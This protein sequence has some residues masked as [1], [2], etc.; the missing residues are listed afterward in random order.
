V[1]EAAEEYV[2]AGRLTVEGWFDETDAWMFRAVDQ[3]QQ[4]EHGDLVE[5][6]VYLGRSAI[7]LGYLARAGERV[8]AVDL[9]ED[10]APTAEQ[11]VEADRWYRGLQR[12][13]FEDSYR[14]FHEQPT[15]VLQGPS[16]EML[17]QVGEGT[18]RIVHIDGSHSF[19]AVTADIDQACRIATPNAVVIFDD[20]AHRHTVG[21]AAAVWGAVLDGRLVPLAVTGW[22]LY[23][24]MPGSSVTV[25]RLRT[26]LEAH[27]LQ[28][29]REH[30][31]A[32]SSVLE[33]AVE[34]LGAPAAGRSRWRRAMVE[35]VPPVAH[36]VR[37]RGV[38]ELVP[39]IAHRIKHRV[40]GIRERRARARTPTVGQRR[41]T[42][43]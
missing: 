6:G 29:L 26:A 8:V 21:V 31:V 13:R 19:E 43:V 25:E 37:Q 30:Q 10:P 23:T 4:D 9:F 35:L 34:G 5:V 27:P 16:H 24:T 3:L 38:I 39:P 41:P 18:A 17:D 36:W 1:S 28:V 22:K 2:R 32:G 12:S 11:E 33:V 15:R 7:L 40:A 42:A 20:I 14:R